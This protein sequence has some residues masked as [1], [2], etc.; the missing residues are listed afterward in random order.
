M[1]E[2]KRFEDV[3][4]LKEKGQVDINMQLA[5]NEVLRGIITSLS[6]F[7]MDFDPDEKGYVILLEPTDGAKELAEIGLN[8]SFENINP[9]SI[10]Y[11]ENLDLYL[12]QILHN[13]EFM[14]FY[15]VEKE[16]IE[17]IPGLEDLIEEHEDSITQ[18][19]LLRRVY[20]ESSKFQKTAEE[21]SEGQEDEENDVPF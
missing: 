12:I 11:D 13:N 2:I 8:G 3:E 10:S 16:G 5:L 18:T 20:E 4:E 1:I 9:E 6:N 19:M 14:N 21:V 15:L 7:H 17:F